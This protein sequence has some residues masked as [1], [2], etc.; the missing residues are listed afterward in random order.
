LKRTK[1]RTW[2]GNKEKLETWDCF[3]QRLFEK[4]T[5]AKGRRVPGGAG[6]T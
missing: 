6:E 1:N 2:V 3:E 5:K 4:N